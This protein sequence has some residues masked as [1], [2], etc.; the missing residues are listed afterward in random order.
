[1]SCSQND[2]ILFYISDNKGK[3]QQRIITQSSNEQNNVSGN[4]L[5]IF[6]R[7]GGNIG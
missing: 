3:N 4:M 2:S 6:V 7:K 1:M 5:N